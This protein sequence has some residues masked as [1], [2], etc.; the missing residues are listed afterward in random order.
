[1]AGNDWSMRI[2]EANDNGVGA[3]YIAVER[4]VK[5]GVY[6]LRYRDTL[7]TWA[8]WRVIG[9]NAPA[10]SS[11]YDAP[12]EVPE[13]A[14]DSG[15][16][17]VSG[18]HQVVWNRARSS[19]STAVHNLWVSAPDMPLRSQMIVTDT[20]TNDV[21]AEADLTYSNVGETRII[22]APITPPTLVTR[23]QATTAPTA[24]MAEP[25]VVPTK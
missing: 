17:S 16:R 24:P 9:V 19:T 1:M 3:K 20:T 25:V 2:G 18:G 7:T 23:T 15:T 8:P 5:D 6:Y 21:L 22:T 10:L 4:R 12:C 13:D 14:S 11:D